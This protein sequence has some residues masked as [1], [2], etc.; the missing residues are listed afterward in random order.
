[1][2]GPMEATYW[3]ALK[4]NPRIQKAAFFLVTSP[5]PSWKEGGLI[6]QSKLS[7]LLSGGDGGGNSET[8]STRNKEKHKKCRC[9]DDTGIFL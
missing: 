3:I 1:M 2:A 4:M 5:D 7:P 9:H 8:G 6:S